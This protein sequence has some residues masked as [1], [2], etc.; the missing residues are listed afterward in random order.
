M[1]KLTSPSKP[2]PAYSSFTLQPTNATAQYQGWRKW[3]LFKETRA[4][5]GAR[6]EVVVMIWPAPFP[7]QGGARNQTIRD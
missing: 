6:P 5:P 3:L 4:H 7:W 2:L 1:S